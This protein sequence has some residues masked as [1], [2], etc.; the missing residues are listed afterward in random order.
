L[1]GFGGFGFG[2]GEVRGGGADLE[3]AF[4]ASVFLG[5]FAALGLGEEGEGERKSDD[6]A[7]CLR[8]SQGRYIREIA[9]I[10]VPADPGV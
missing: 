1:D 5:P 8:I 2:E 6:Q 7:H 3:A 10:S 9:V 4:A